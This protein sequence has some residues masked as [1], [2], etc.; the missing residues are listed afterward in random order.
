MAEEGNQLSQ[1][2]SILITLIARIIFFGGLGLALIG[3]FYSFSDGR[4]HLMRQP[5]YKETFRV[6]VFIFGLATAFVGHLLAR[7]RVF[8]LVFFLLGCVVIVLQDIGTAA[9]GGPEAFWYG[10]VPAVVDIAVL[11]YVYHRRGEFKAQH[12]LENILVDTLKLAGSGQ[13]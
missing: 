7:R 5:V 3:A 1:R 10:Y 13:G 8:G 6:V 2:R 12:Q 9:L 4:W 11:A